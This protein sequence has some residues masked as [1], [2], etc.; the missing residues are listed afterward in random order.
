MV[1]SSTGGPAAL[2]QVLGA[3]SEAP[4]C[5]FLVAQHMPAG[6]TRSFAE[7]LGRLTPLSA[8]EARSGEIG[9]VMKRLRAQ[10]IQPVGLCMAASRHFRTLYAAASDP[11]GVAKGMAGVRP[12]VV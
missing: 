12:P 3:F 10:G 9:P 6:F 7:R 11:G 2:V 5:A 4:D 8:A 1:G